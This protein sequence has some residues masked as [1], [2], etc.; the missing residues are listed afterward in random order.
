LQSGSQAINVPLKRQQL[1][2][3]KSSDDELLGI[4]EG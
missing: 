1:N 2:G 3:R 4:G